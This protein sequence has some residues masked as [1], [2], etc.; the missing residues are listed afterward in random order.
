METIPCTDLKCPIILNAQCVFYESTNLVNTGI[1]KNTNLEVALQKIDAA[2]GRATTSGTSG[3]SGVSGS[4]G[5]SGRD[6]TSG[7]TGTSGNTGSSGLTGSSGTSG[8]KGDIYRA[9]YTGTLT[10]NPSG[11]SGVVVNIGTGYAYTPGQSIIIAYD[12]NN[13]METVV[14]SYESD[15]TLYCTKPGLVVGTGTYNN[16]SVNLDGATGGDGSSG[17]SGSSGVTGVSGT[18][19]VTG[20]SGTAGTSGVTV[21]GTSGTSASSSILPFEINTNTTLTNTHNGGII[22]VYGTCSVTIPNGLVAGFN[23]SFVTFSGVT[24]TL[25]LGGS[26]VLF[27]N[28]GL[29][30]TGNNSFTLQARLAANNYIAQGAI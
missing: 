14:V 2:L 27:N 24:L 15:G 12:N 16:W 22:M 8:L 19:G 17:T 7:I 30:M 5:S 20:T 6:G 23:A 25:V 3:T 10:L 29:T 21:S 26:V 18:S 11:T 13:Y 9:N 4:S 1:T 28:A